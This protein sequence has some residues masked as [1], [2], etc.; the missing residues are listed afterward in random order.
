[1][2]SFINRNKNKSLLSSFNVCFIREILFW[3]YLLEVKCSSRVLFGCLVERIYYFL[4]YFLTFNP[5]YTTRIEWVLDDVTFIPIDSGWRTL[6][7]SFLKKCF[8]PS[9]FSDIQITYNNM[10]TDTI[11]IFWATSISRYWRIYLNDH[12]FA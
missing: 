11:N 6:L 9:V 3:C 5:F 7:R 12:I 4:V 2:C 8:Q 1:M 10:R